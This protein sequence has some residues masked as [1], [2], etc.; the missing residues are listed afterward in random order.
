MD[1]SRQM[2]PQE[3]KTSVASLGLAEPAPGRFIQRGHASSIRLI[4][5][6]TAAK[7]ECRA[8]PIRAGTTA[9]K[10]AGKIPLGPSSAASFAAESCAGTTCASWCSEAKCRE[11]PPKLRLEGQRIT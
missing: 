4:S 7:D 3:Q 10:A 2:S 5:L 1:H 6:L 9:Q 8:W 11:G